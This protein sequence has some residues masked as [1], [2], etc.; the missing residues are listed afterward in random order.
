LLNDQLVPQAWR[1]AKSRDTGSISPVVYSFRFPLAI[2]ARPTV[3]P[4][5]D[6]DFGEAQRSTQ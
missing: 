4:T 3:T 1:I 2:D 6:A 5:M